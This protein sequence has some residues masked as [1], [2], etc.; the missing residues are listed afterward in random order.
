[1]DEFYAV[2]SL[3]MSI[4]NGQKEIAQAHGVSE[5]EQANLIGQKLQELMYLLGNTEE[6]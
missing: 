5:Q 6:A 3:D 2:L 4:P 1:M